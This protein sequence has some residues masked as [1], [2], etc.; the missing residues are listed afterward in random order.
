MTLLDQSKKP[1]YFSLVNQWPI[2]T[3]LIWGHKQVKVS[4]D[5]KEENKHIYILQSIQITLWTVKEVIEKVERK[6]KS[7]DK[8]K[9]EKR[10]EEKCRGKE[11]EE[12]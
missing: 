3:K 7:K 5:F 12:T 9:G 6:N 4:V 11:K 1:F 2:E 10:R 8:E